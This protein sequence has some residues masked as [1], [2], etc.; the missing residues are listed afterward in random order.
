MFLSQARN[1]CG[2]LVRLW[3]LESVNKKYSLVMLI[4]T[5]V[6]CHVQVVKTTSS[7]GYIHDLIT[8]KAFFPKLQIISKLCNLSYADT[9]TLYHIPFIKSEHKKCW[10]TENQCRHWSK[11]S[12]RK[13]LFDLGLHWLFIYTCL[14]IYLRYYTVPDRILFSSKK[15]W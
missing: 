13:K 11:C 10:L 14:N 8:V 7:N 12:F 9:V 5:C 6:S 4:H 1:V 3:F 15:Y 2:H